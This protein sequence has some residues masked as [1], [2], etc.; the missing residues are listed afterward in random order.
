MI[1]SKGDVKRRINMLQICV[2]ISAVPFFKFSKHNFCK[3]NTIISKLNN[4]YL[5]TIACILWLFSSFILFSAARVMKYMIHSNAMWNEHSWLSLLKELTDRKLS[6]K[7]NNTSI[8]LISKSNHA[9]LSFY[10]WEYNL[11]IRISK[12]SCDAQL[13]YIVLQHIL[14][15][16]KYFK[17][18]WNVLLYKSDKIWCFDEAFTRPLFKSC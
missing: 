16:A 1:H 3:M 8:T 4:E 15:I 11:L 13:A 2:K 18:L 7:F 10:T 14:Y 12:M 17:C 5:Q 6:S 9:N